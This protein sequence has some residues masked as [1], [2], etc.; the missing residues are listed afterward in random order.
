[1]Q[2]PV[3]PGLFGKV[4]KAL[5]PK[6]LH[7]A[8]AL[9]LLLPILRGLK[10]LSKRSSSLLSKVKRGHGIGGWSVRQ[11]SSPVLPTGLS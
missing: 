1:L 10:T 11:M 6:P 2:L 8:L 9:P 3:L 7:S 4:F 5:L